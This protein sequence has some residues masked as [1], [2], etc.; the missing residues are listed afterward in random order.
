MASAQITR[1]NKVSDF[2][3]FR[4]WQGGSEAVPFERI[5]V[6]YGQNGSGKSTLASLFSRCSQDGDGEKPS[7][8]LS[9][10]VGG[11]TT[12]I[13]E[14]TTSFWVEV[15]VFNQGFIEK[16][17]QF[18]A[19]LGAQ[20]SAIL[21]LGE[22]QVEA[23][24]KIVQLTDTKDELQEELQELEERC[25]NE[26]EERR[27]KYRAVGKQIVSDLQHSRVTKYRSSSAY[28]L[29]HVKLALDKYWQPH[30]VS[31]N[32]VADREL[33]NSLP[34]PRL[35][36]PQV[37]SFNQD[38]T[39]AKIN[40]VLQRD[41]VIEIIDQLVDQPH[42][43]RWVQHGIDLHE[44]LDTC[45]FCGSEILSQRRDQ[46]SRHFSTSLTDLQRDLFTY[47]ALL[48]QWVDNYEQLL[49]RLPHPEQLHPSLRERWQAAVSIL[50]R[51]VDQFSV[52]IFPIVELMDEKL[53]NPLKTLEFPEKGEI[54]QPFL[55]RIQGLVLDHNE[56]VYKHTQ[57]VEDAARRVECYHLEKLQAESC[58][59][60]QVIHQVQREIHQ[61]E[62]SLNQVTEEIYSLEQA[63]FDQLQSTHEMNAMI[64]QLLGHN[65]LYFKLGNER[66]HYE[67]LRNGKPATHLS[68]GERSII[69]LAYFL[70]KLKAE[71]KAGLQPIVVIDDPSS[72]LD[73]GMLYGIGSLLW[74]ELVN[75]QLVSQVILFTH[76]FEF[77]R[78]WTMRLDH[79]T[80]E[81]KQRVG[82]YT[83]HEL[84]RT[85]TDRPIPRTPK[86]EPWTRD[87][88]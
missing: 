32:I 41:V 62:S 24:Q 31:Q 35:D 18:D 65:D 7:V 50:T 39:L 40:E 13:T 53:Q 80:D 83:L 78:L 45:L 44:G 23:K 75:D 48:E 54:I 63:S 88:R 59:L 55:D 76:S 69:A 52:S 38:E 21:T 85:N 8:L 36:T 79:M 74:R 6:I 66:S 37:L 34:L 73:A 25:S 71:T 22:A 27:R 56:L 61:V 10:K 29:R 67:I 77:F 64:A 14:Y 70:V 4:Q 26:E 16:N 51:E 68:D 49:N 11:K 12:T 57:I 1:I 46:L 86:L 58:K 28:N 60:D 87:R 47:K 5:N 20:S 33:A 72:H 30:E 3:I 15:R 42:R 81:V 19:P 84:T 9:A 17:L 82:G 2:R 43:A